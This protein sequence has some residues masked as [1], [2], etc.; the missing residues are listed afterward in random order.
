[1]IL[2]RQS[3]GRKKMA[4]EEVQLVQKI[5]CFVIFGIFRKIPKYGKTAIYG[6]MVKNRVIRR[7]HVTFWILKLVC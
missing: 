6:I 5:R 4:S 2:S 7:I 3:S 1:M